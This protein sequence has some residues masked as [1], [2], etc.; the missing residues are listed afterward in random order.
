[1]ATPEIPKRRK[2]FS[3]FDLANALAHVGIREPKTWEQNFAMKEPSAFFYENLNRLDAFDT[4]RSE[5]AKLLIAD[6]FFEEAVQPY[7]DKI[8]IFKEVTLHGEKNGGVV[9]Y[10]VS[11]R[12]MVPTIPFLCV[13]EA[14]KDDFDKGLAQCLVEMQTMAELNVK[15]NKNIDVYGI[16]TN[17]RQWQFYKKDTEGIFYESEDCVASDAPRLLGILDVI[18]AACAANLD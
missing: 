7:K 9:D 3:D 5:S 2:S 18:F 14:K 1:M 6:A 15:E 12:S 17:G 10:I 16:V 8:R 13:T 11:I 4:A